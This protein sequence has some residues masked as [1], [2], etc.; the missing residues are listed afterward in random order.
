MGDQ[1]LYMNDKRTQRHNFVFA[2]TLCERCCRKGGGNTLNSNFQVK[3]KA[4][5]RSHG[6]NNK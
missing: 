2:N 3:L 5:S 4:F 6:K 1:K